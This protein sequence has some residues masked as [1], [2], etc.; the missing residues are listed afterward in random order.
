[1]KR[2]FSDQGFTMIE[3]LIVIAI[4][5][6]LAVTILSAVNPVEQIGRSRD[7]TSKSDAEQLL[8]AIDHFNASRGL[9][10]WQDTTTDP[11]QVVFGAVTS[12]FPAGS[13]CTMLKNLG[14]DSSDA[15]CPGTDELKAA[16]ISRVTDAGT[17]VL[18]VGYNGRTGDSIYICYNPQSISFKE[19]ANERCKNPPSDYPALACG[20]CPTTSLG[21]HTN[22]I[23]LP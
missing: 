5:G 14:A 1:M 6:I 11:G 22:C 12:A 2:F 7:S 9:W 10:P 17:N 13:S 8:N 18:Y 3:L 19:E 16:F 15:A 23:C 4:L 20:R 21:K